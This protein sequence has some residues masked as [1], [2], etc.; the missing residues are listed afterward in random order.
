MS[1]FLPM[2]KLFGRAAHSKFVLWMNVPSPLFQSYTFCERPA[3]HGE[4]IV[5]F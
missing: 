1:A 2:H 3:W 5:I 4:K